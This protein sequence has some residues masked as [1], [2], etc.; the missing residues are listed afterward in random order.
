MNSLE[1]RWPFIEWRKPLP[2]AWQ[3]A[4]LFTCRICVAR[5]GLNRESLHLWVSPQQ[6]VDHIE[7]EHP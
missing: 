7:K 5:F 1:E 6:V 4:S 3:D 2:V